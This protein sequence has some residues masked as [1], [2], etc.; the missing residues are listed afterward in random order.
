MVKKRSTL[1]IPE[2]L[3]SKVGVYPAIL[4]GFLYVEGGF[5]GNLQDLMERLN[6]SRYMLLKSRSLLRDA[7]YIKEK[8]FGHPQRLRIELTEEG[9]RMVELCIQR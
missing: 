6:F 1:H 3:L 2:K 9:K 4:L 8:R 5:E 7:G